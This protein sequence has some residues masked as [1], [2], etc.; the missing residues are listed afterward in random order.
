MKKIAF[1]LIIVSNVSF[2]KEI[3]RPMPID[4]NYIDFQVYGTTIVQSDSVDQSASSSTYKNVAY[5]FTNVDIDFNFNKNV[6]IVT[7]TSIQNRKNGFARPYA[8]T[9]YANGSNTIGTFF[10]DTSLTSRMIA[11]Q[12]HNKNTS[13]T[14]GKLRPLAGVANGNNAQMMQEDWYG[15]Y[16]AMVNGGYTNTNKLGAQF[17]T[18][19]SLAPHSR[20]TL[21]IALFKNDTTPL[22]DSAFGTQGVYGYTLPQ[23]LNGI[24][25]QR[26]AGNTFAPSSFSILVSNES[27]L[28]D[29]QTISY[30]GYYRKQDI[31]K[32]SGDFLA[33]E[34]TIAVSGKYEKV[35]ENATL[36]LFGNI[37]SVS[38]AF[39]VK[40]LSEKYYTASAYTNVDNFVIAFV[41]NIYTM[42]DVS[43]ININGVNKSISGVQLSQSQISFGYKFSNAYKVD[44]AYRQLTDG[45]TQKTAQGIG[46]G[47]RYN[48]G[49]KDIL[50]ER[51]K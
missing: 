29:D 36:G 26:E 37:A 46:L 30:T 27:E 13:L 2:A 4:K 17:N 14:I 18:E 47:F 9:D 24:I 22:N 43:N 42:S 31:D 33:P 49:T 16:G 28:I 19:F 5:T 44:I 23:S 15:V 51:P 8:M 35:L 25:S 34:I 7:Q 40:D 32:Q 39:G 48:I 45:K 10:T 6:S 38:N 41:Y 3:K 21:E 50:G 12:L 1:I 20:Q 11:F